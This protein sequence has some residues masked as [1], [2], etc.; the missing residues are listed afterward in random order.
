M[1]VWDRGTYANLK[2]DDEGEP[3]P[4]ADQVSAGHV[5][6]RLDGGEK[7]AGGYA[8]TRMEGRDEEVWLLVKMDDDAADARR[9][10][11]STEP[12]SVKTGRT[13]DEVAGEE[14]S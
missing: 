13:L 11:V 1:I 2:E 8:L 6:I 5:T 12:E 9:N 14:D 10:P 4:V 3:V 7:L